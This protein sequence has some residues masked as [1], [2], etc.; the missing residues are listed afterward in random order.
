MYIIMWTMKTFP[1]HFYA[2]KSDV[3]S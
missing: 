2:H 3:K 1:T